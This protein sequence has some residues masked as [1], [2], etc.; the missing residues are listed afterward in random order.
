LTP[1]VKSGRH[2]AETV[3]R[4]FEE[5]VKKDLT[6]SLDDEDIAEIIRIWAKLEKQ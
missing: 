4:L 6:E 1:V 2:F 3:R 5:S